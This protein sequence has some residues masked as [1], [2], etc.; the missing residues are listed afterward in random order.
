M[1][2]LLTYF[3]ILL[4]FLSVFMVLSVASAHDTGCREIPHIYEDS[5]PQG[6]KY[7]EITEI[8]F[9]APKKD[10]AGSVAIKD[11]TKNTYVS[12]G[13]DGKTL[14]PHLFNSDHCC[15]C[16]FLLQL[17]TSKISDGDVLFV[18][19]EYIG[20]G[21]APIGSDNEL[22]VHIKNESGV[23]RV[24]FELKG[25]SKGGGIYWWLVDFILKPLLDA[26]YWAVSNLIQLIVSIPIKIF[27][28]MMNAASSALNFL[29][30]L[31]SSIVQGISD[32]FGIAAPLGAVIVGITIF[33]GG[34]MVIK[35]IL[36][37]V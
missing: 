24:Y 12:L 7:G 21:A 6:V 25:N 9:S 20:A 5:V 10:T 14:A 23:E 33:I 30:N 17:D 32:K 16:D 28:W 36:Y 37:V 29:S 31:F 1:K 4:I 3:S 34:Y 26:I 13:D 11:G 22:V 8:F 19:V 15:D 18:E 2:K 27:G 35:L